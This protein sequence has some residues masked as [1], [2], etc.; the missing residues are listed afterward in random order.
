MLQMKIALQKFVILVQFE[1]ILCVSH[2]TEKALDNFKQKV[3]TSTKVHEEM[4]WIYS[5]IFVNSGEIV[6]KRPNNPKI[7][8]TPSFRLLVNEFPIWIDRITVNQKFH[9]RK[10]WNER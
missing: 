1:K 8:K 2:A 5:L 7:Y 4:T 10:N 3:F 6:K 9:F